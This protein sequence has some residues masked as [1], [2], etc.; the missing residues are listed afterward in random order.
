M[1]GGNRRGPMGMGP[2]TGRGAGFC[3]GANA[4]GFVSQLAGAFFGGGRGHGGRGRRNMFCATGL[5][6]WMRAG[7]GAAAAVA[8]SQFRAPTREEELDVLK[9]QADEASAV[10]E[11]IRKR[12]SELEAGSQ[13]A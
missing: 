6:G 4:P 5:P 2:R 3:G 10:L 13:N 7:V 9:Q 8:A 11:G 12:I 1:P